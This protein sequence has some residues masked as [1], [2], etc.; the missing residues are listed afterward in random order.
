M[1]TLET[2]MKTG[3][4]YSWF[5]LTEDIIKK[6]FVLSGSEQNPDLT[7]KDIKLLL[8]ER[9]GSKATSPVEAFMDKGPDFIL[10]DD[11]GTLVRKMNDLAG[12]DLLDYETIKHEIKARDLQIDNPFTKD[13]QVAFINNAR[14]FLGDKLV[15]TAKPHKILSGRNGRL[16]AVKLNIISRKTLGGIQTNLDGQALNPSMQP[17]Q[18]LYAAGEAS[19]FGGGGVHGYRAL[20]GTFLGGCIFSGIRAAEGIHHHIQ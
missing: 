15:R 5:I 11:L 1:H 13:P 17:I 14:Q 19:G 20:E 6:E 10:A 7:D 12:N 8:Q 4:D 3:Y 9:L 18:G 2:I 16:I